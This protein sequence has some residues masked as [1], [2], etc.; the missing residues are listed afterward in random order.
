MNQALQ[1]YDSKWLKCY[2]DAQDIIRRHAPEKLAAFVAAMKPLHTDPAFT[3]KDVP[4]I[5]DDAQ[6][7]EIK[8]IIRSIPATGMSLYEVK[9][10]GRL[11]VHDHPHFT[12][13]QHGLTALVSRLAGQEVEPCYNFLSLYSRLGVC[14][15][16]LDAPSAK[17]TLDI[18]ID[19]SDPWP[20]HFSQI[21][22]WPDKPL[23]IDGD[24][25]AAI[26]TSPDLT[27]TSK[28]LMPGNAILFSGSSQWHYRDPLPAA[29]RKAHCDLLFF[30]YIPKGTAEIVAPRNWARLFDV[31][32]IAGIPGIEVVV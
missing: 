27:F 12:K 13:L 28:T 29:T 24:W 30:H 25:Q 21:V 9:R 22:P 20:I 19:Q 5:F 7:D 4:G 11:I 10:F 3:V 15:P 18:C 1:W 14:E 8:A 6:L 2:F 16:H 26:K 31:P 17:W 23:R 32:Q